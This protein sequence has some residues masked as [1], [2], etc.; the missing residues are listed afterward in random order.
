MYMY[1]WWIQLSCMLNPFYWMPR[2]ICWQEITAI[3]MLSYQMYVDNLLEDWHTDRTVCVLLG[4]GLKSH[5][6]SYMWFKISVKIVTRLTWSGSS[7]H[8]QLYCAHLQIGSFSGQ[9][10]DFIIL[11]STSYT[12]YAVE[13]PS[14]VSTP[15]SKVQLNRTRGFQSINFQ[16][17][18]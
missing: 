8:E 10:K 3:S 14:T 2:W 6:Y 12:I 9:S 13:M 4:L 18:A 11:V 7:T 5:I 16:T 1:L 15:H 17:L